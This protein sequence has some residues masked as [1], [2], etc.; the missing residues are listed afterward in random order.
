[1]IKL[2]VGNK[3]SGKTKTL[4]QMINDAAKVT[5]GD[6]I[7]IEKGDSLKFDLSYKIRLINIEDYSI[8][9]S[10]SYYGFIAGLMACNYDI[11]EIFCDATFKILGGKDLAA[12]ESLITR[13]A[14]LAEANNASITLTVSC[15][16]NDLP[17]S[18]ARYAL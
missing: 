7:C 14:A 16:Q 15:D 12:L 5:K 17:Q 10:D 4:M 6:V 8:S 18:I 13:L 9:G 2:I 3:G 11:T 1:M